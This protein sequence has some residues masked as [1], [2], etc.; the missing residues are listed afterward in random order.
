MG[1]RFWKSTLNYIVSDLKLKIN[2]TLHRGCRK[3]QKRND[4]VRRTPT[5]KNKSGIDARKAQKG[6]KNGKNEQRNDQE[7]A[8]SERGTEG[9]IA[10]NDL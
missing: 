7:N 5:L 6:D 2:S 1:L 4:V 8:G 10:G 9:G 3:N